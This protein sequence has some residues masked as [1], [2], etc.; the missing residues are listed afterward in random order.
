MTLA[1]AFNYKAKKPA[2][3]LLSC[4][5]F[6]EANFLFHQQIKKQATEIFDDLDLNLSISI[7]IFI[8]EKHN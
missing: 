2:T 8:S 7:N 6:F 5:L 1:D 3:Q 4:G